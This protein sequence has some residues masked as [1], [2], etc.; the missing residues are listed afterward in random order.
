MNDDIDTSNSS[1]WILPD[2]DLM[3]VMK[4]LI[5]KVPNNHPVLAYYVR[6]AYSIDNSDSISIK[7]YAGLYHFGSILLVQK[8][9][10]FLN[11]QKF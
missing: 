11:K 6:A 2:E 1:D 4:V 7:D 9:C 5:E 8:I 10:Q 3:D